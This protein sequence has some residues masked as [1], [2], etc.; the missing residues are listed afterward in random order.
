MS[1]PAQVARGARVPALPAPLAMIAGA[2]SVQLGGAVAVHAFT[3]STPLG[4]TFL[5]SLFAAAL[6]ALAVHSLPRTRAAWRAS[7]PF[8]VVMGCM[9]ACF[10]EAIERLPL[11]AAVT[12]EFWGP[13]AV[14]VATSRRRTDLIWVALAVAGVSLLGEGFADAQLGGLVFITAAGGLWAVYIVLGRRLAHATSGA[15]ALIPACA[16]SAAVLA[17]PGI[18][19]ART[20]LADPR[21]VG[22]CALVGLLGTAIPYAIEMYAMRRMPARTFSVLL[23]VHPAVA[24]LVG[25]AVLSQGLGVRDAIAIACVVAASTGALRTGFK[26]GGVSGGLESPPV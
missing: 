19:S 21:L 3:R 18:A 15:A 1:S 9:N 25:A 16:I 4:V 10:Y 8:G 7:L 22:L 20:S 17:A 12:I 24:A 2:L 6:L 5:R 23:S 26:S 14:A 11:G 13:I